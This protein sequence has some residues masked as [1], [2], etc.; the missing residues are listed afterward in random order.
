MLNYRSMT[1]HKKLQ[2]YFIK[3]PS[4]YMY[5]ICKFK[6]ANH[7]LP[8]VIGRYTGVALDNRICTL[9]NLSEIGDEFHYLFKCSF[10]NEDRFKYVKRYY[11]SQ[12]NTHKMTQLFNA[13]SNKE[14]LNLGKFIYNII[15]H[16][17][18][19]NWKLTHCYKVKYS[20]VIIWN[21]D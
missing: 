18:S 3:L 19:G 12:P 7:K 1:T 13:T 8:I 10:F 16:F 2:N 21:I 15:Q 14:I 5:A 4:Q 17:K 9:C 11:Y 6:C 20:W